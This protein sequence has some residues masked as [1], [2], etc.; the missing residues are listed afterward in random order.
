MSQKREAP[1]QSYDFGCR[2]GFPEVLLGFIL[3]PLGSMNAVEADTNY[4]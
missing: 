4:F 1:I 2:M 3:L